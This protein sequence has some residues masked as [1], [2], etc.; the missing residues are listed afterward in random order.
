MVEII[1]EA[2][3]EK[4]ERH[5]GKGSSLE[6]KIG[7]KTDTFVLKP[8]PLSSLPDLFRVFKAF[9]KLRPGS[10]EEFFDKLDEETSKK[11]TQLAMDTMKLSYPNMSEEKLELF[12]S[13]NFMPILT[14]VFEINDLGLKKIAPRAL[15][16]IKKMRGPEKK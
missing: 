13:T 10:E 16:R 9:A 5:I 7:D 14:K 12:V 3:L 1:E 2:E 11:M 4:F 8:L 6:L 15:A